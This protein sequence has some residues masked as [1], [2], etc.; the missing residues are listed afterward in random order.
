MKTKLKIMF[1]FCICSLLPT[2]AFAG[3]FGI[4]KDSEWGVNISHKST[5]NTQGYCIEGFEVAIEKGGGKID[6]EIELKFVGSDPEDTYTGSFKAYLYGNSVGRSDRKFVESRDLCFDKD[7][8]MIV[9]AIGVVNGRKR[10]LIEEGKIRNPDF[11]PLPII[12]GK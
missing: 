11:I 8:I 12:V 1:F 6:L 3:K 7:K 4:Y 2:L 9:K 10:D 5:A